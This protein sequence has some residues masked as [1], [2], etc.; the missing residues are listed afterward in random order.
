MMKYLY[1]ALLV[2][3]A[4]VVLI[5]SFQNRETVTVTFLSW[6]TTLPLFVVVIGAYLLGMASGGSV[7]GFVRHSVKGARAKPGPAERGTR[8]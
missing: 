1:V 4:A 7:A 8:E 6:S 3:L 5:F 2:A